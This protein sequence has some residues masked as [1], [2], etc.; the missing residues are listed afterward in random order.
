MIIAEMNDEFKAYLEDCIKN[1]IP[2]S[3]NDDND[4]E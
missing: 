2:V 3:V 4:D 1:A